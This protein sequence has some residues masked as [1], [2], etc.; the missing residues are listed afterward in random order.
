M[1]LTLILNLGMAAG[2]LVSVEPVPIVR[3]GTKKKKKPFIGW[4][5][6]RFDRLAREDEEIVEILGNIIR[7]L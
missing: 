2:S 1:L 6:D 7:T 4:D 5:H 3:G